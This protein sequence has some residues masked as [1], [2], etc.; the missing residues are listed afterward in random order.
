ML[1]IMT[2][3]IVHHYNLQ[4][5]LY[6]IKISEESFIVFESY[7]VQAFKIGDHVFGNFSKCGILDVLNA[8]SLSWSKVDVQVVSCNEALAIHKVSLS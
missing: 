1:M 2:Q 8:R 7:D 4:K 3:G 6:V 5:G